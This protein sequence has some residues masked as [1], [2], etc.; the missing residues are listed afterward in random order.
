MNERKKSSI[1]FWHSMKTRFMLVVVVVAVAVVVMYTLM[2]M[3]GIRSNIRQ[4]YSN[5]LLDLTLSYG[6]ELDETLT[7][8]DNKMLEHV[9]T[10]QGIVEKAQLEGI[11]SSYGYIVST[12][13]TMLYHPTAEKIG[14]PVENETVKKI[15]AEVEAGK[16][17]EPEVVSYM[18]DGTQKY[19]ACYVSENGFIFVMTADDTDLL[20]AANKLQARGLGTAVVVLIFGVFVAWICAR[21]MTRP[22]IR[23]TSAVDRIAGFDLTEDPELIA[24]DKNKGETGA[25]AHAVLHMKQALRSM[26]QQIREQSANIHQAS[27]QLEENATATSGNVDSIETAVNEIATGATN[28]ATETQRATEDVVMMGTMIEDTSTQVENLNSTAVE[29]SNASASARDALEELNHINEKAIESIEVIYQQTHTTNESALK[30]KDVTELIASIAEETNLLSLNASIEAARA[31]DA[32][33]GFAVVASQIQKLAEQSNASTKKID[34]IIHML[35]TDSENAVHTMEEVREVMHQQSEKVEQTKQVFGSVNQGIDQSIS[36]MEAISEHTRQ[37]DHARENIV[38]TVQNL[39][40]IAQENA[41]STEETNAV[42]MEIGGVMQ[43]ISG[44]VQG[45]RRIADIL[46]KNVE[47]FKL[48]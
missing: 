21:R 25:I 41:A 38:D 10:M 34:D 15:I 42:V 33:K 1:S 31:G 39:S 14:Q 46:E 2:I 43:Q 12:D 28:Q 26:V 23:M 48:D 3:P 30:I 20:E 40:A 6:S 13:G 4:I 19:A 44:N 36:G 7:R 35:L 9:H 5:Y 47:T 16:T 37:L 8:V 11:D 17:P 29:M 22:L 24:L 27:G 32:G 45:L 18:F